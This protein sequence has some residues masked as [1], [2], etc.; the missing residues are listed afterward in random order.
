MRAVSEAGSAGAPAPRFAG[1]LAA[2]LTVAAAL[3]LFSGA[4]SG[5]D[6]RLAD[7]SAQTQRALAGCW[8]GTVTEPGIGDYLLTVEIA[9]NE[10]AGLVHFDYQPRPCVAELRRTGPDEHAPML[11]GESSGAAARFRERLIEGRDICTDDLTA[12]LQLQPGGRRVFFEEMMLGE[13]VVW[14]MLD[15]RP[16]AE[17]GQCAPVDPGFVNAGPK[18]RA[19]A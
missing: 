2:A 5:A 16:D 17:S 3:A 19:P 15:R 9:P 6:V 12:R 8:R 13:A 14:G 11:G 18:N 10:M 7:G 1:A 4:P